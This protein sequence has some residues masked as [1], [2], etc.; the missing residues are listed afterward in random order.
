MHMQRNETSYTPKEQDPWNKHAEHR[1]RIKDAVAAM[2]N[3]EKV[4]TKTLQLI[5]RRIEEFSALKENTTLEP[6]I[7][8]E[9]ETLE[10]LKARLT[11]HPEA[12]TFLQQALDG[13]HLPTHSEFFSLQ[14]KGENDDTQTN[15]NSLAS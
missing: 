15:K 4:D 7:F 3:E 11:L 1:K 14:K 10:E 8:P 2:L 9:S 12:Q 6:L 5:V 13:T